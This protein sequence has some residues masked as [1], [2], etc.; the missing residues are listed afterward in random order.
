MRNRITEIAKKYDADVV[1]FTAASDFPKDS[2]L[3]E[4][5]PQVK[6]VVGL[7][8]R[9]LRGIYRGVEE[10]T[11]Y[12][13]Y[14]TMGVE[15]LEETV[16]PY[17]MLRVAS[18]IEAEGFC[19]IPQR[20]HQT[21]MAEENS[22]NPEVDYTD[23]FRGVETECQLDF[24]ETAIIC[25]I[26]ERGLGNR[27]LNKEFGPFIRY[28]FVL[29][30]AE[31]EPTKKE[32]YNLCDNCG[33]CVKACPGG[34]ISDKGELDLWRCAVYYNGANGSKNPFMPPE[35]FMEFDNRLDIINGTAQFDTDGAKE[36]LDN[37]FFYPPAKHFYRVSIC[38][39]AC[40]REC[41][42][43]L[44]EKGVLSRKFNKKFR[45][46]E[47]WKLDTKQFETLKREKEWKFTGEED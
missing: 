41:Y 24:E 23:I 26:G 29:T 13:Q 4:I 32:V 19:A 43:H 45:D 5:F 38:G 8:F 27:V 34:A 42:I 9:V 28:C 17:A 10:G 44:E 30:D 2:K 46:G 33:K 1:T 31:I 7:G 22:T 47:D 18:I 3:F 14:T 15:N 21:I 11:T 36:I 20:R 12:Y 37:I 39:R 16:M 35:A 6:T 40:D 25:G